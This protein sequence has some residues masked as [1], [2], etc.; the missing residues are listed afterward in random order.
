MRVE[1]LRGDELVVRDELGARHTLT[2]VD[3]VPLQR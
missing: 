1:A 3:A 2:L